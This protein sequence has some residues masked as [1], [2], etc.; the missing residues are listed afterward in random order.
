MMNKYNIPSSSRCH[1]DGFGHSAGDLLIR[2]Y[3]GCREGTR[4]F[5]FESQ[6]QR[7]RSVRNNCGDRVLQYFGITAKLAVLDEQEISFGG[8]RW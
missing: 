6:S 8:L 3:A 7:V 4:F 5:A 2:V 1:T